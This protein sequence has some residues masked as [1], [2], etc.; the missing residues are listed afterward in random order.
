LGSIIDNCLSATKTSLGT[1]VL[2]AEDSLELLI[3]L[4][5]SLLEQNISDKW[6]SIYNASGQ[7]QTIFEFQRLIKQVRPFDSFKLK[8]S[9]LNYLTTKHKHGV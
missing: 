4:I 2:R 7:F 1:L 3:A 5:V 8:F 9:I 6:N